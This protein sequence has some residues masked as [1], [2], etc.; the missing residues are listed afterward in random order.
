M[1]NLLSGETSPYL[2]QH[3][4]NPVHWHPWGN[5]AWEKAKAENKLVIVSI[6][7]SACHWCHVMEHESFE[8]DGVAALMNKDY[9]CIKVDREERPDVDQFYMDAAQ[10]MSGRGGWPLNAFA[11]PDGRPVYAG[12]YFPKTSWTG[13]LHELAAGYKSRPVKYIE[14]AEKMLAGIKGLSLIE[15]PAEEKE[16]S[17]ETAA[18]IY[19]SFSRIFDHV[20]G[21]KGR[22]PK[23][24]MPDNYF[25]LLRYHYYSKNEEALAHTFLTLGKM[26]AGGIY[27]QIGG[28]FARYSTDAEWKVPHFEKMLYDNAQLI[29]LY[30][31]AYSISKE[32]RYKKIVYQTVEWLEREMYSGCGPFYSALDADSEGEEGKFYV[33]KEEELDTILGADSVLAKKYYCIGGKGFW[34]HGNNILLADENVQIDERKLKE[35]EAKLLEFRNQRIHPGLDNKILT[36]W[37]AMLAIGLIKA[38]NSFNDTRFLTMSR[39]IIDFIES[40]LMMD[41]KLYHTIKKGEPAIPAFLEDYAFL[42]SALNDLYAATFDEKYLSES[43]RLTEIVLSEFY[44]NQSGYFYFTSV[45]STELASRKIDT[46][47]N[48]I[49]SANSVMGHNLFILGKL[50]DKDEYIFIAGKMLNGVM[51]N[52]IEHGP[53]YSNWAMLFLK[54]NHPIFEIAICGENALK[55]RN[56]L[57][58]SFRPDAIIFGSELQNSTVPLL[59]NKFITGKTV[60]YT[61]VDKTCGLPEEV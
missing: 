54:M 58:L 43:G 26:A 8:D 25:F 52:V 38:Y 47:D 20:H 34:E 22:A 4:N 10:I 19:E 28:G 12:T 60:V 57:A 36:G 13:L 49:S 51:E 14:Y 3:A 21:G 27:D 5:E 7:Y 9:I 42:I 1:P 29:G 37:N 55:H 32:E 11:L 61:C 39:S 18:R 16:Y 6:G 33:W 44:D 59:E 53:Y 50:F 45:E 30:S 56:K 41:G 23:F 35:I 46:S 31:E 15:A 40:S 48:V 2:L 17:P 24:P